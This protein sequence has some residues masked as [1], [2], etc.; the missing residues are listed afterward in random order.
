MP[1]ANG[2]H[3]EKIVI[4]KILKPQGI[5]GELKIFPIT[6]DVERFRGIDSVFLEGREQP[7]KVHGVRINGSDVFLYIEG[8]T[9][10]DAAEAVRGKL[11]S[12]RREHAVK[13]EGSHFIC[14]LV[15]C[16]VEFEDGEKIG[17]LSEV[18][19]HGSADVYAVSPVQGAKAVMFPALERVFSSI[20]TGA[21]R[22][23]VVRAA[24]NEVA[25]Y[26]D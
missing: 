10:R 22:I 23:V 16:A 2:K 12:V 14:D 17:V 8:V 3:M 18:Y 20:D 6:G 1:P 15:G 19:Q 5:R 26:E 9:G 13:P 11:L 7:A 25:C 21:K 4:G 24:F